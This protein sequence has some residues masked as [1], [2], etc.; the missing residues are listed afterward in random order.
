MVALVLALVACLMGWWPFCQSGSPA[1][2]FETVRM[3]VGGSV[4]SCGI[5]QDSM[6]Q[7]FFPGDDAGLAHIQAT[8]AA[9]VRENFK[10]PRV[11]RPSD[12]ELS[13]RN[14]QIMTAGM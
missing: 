5:Q 8:E 10:D 3:P 6:Q 13:A 2:T 9:L 1:P 7:T 4:T 12:G 11:Y 14:L